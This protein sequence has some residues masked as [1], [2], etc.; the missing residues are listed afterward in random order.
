MIKK[1][2]EK[3]KKRK[4][5]KKEIVKSAHHRNNGPEINKEKKFLSTLHK[6][7]VNSLFAN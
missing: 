2:K 3:K 6:H 7:L 4:E 5:K 1:K